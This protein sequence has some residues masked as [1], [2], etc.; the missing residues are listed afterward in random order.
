VF[1]V[2]LKI[3][4]GLV[5]PTNTATLSCERSEAGFWF[6]GPHLSLGGPY[7]AV[8]SYCMIRISLCTD[9]AQ[10]S[11]MDHVVFITQS[12]VCNTMSGNVQY[13]DNE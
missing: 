12:E 9:F 7:Y 11:D 10:A 3:F 2:N 1:R 6:R 4:L 5:L 13:G 8:L